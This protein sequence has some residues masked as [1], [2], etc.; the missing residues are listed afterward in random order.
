MTARAPLSFDP[1]DEAGRQWHARWGEA[2][3]PMMAVTSLMRVQQLVLG[4]LNELLAPLELTFARYELLML[5][6]LSGGGSLPLS[7]L[8]VRLQVHPT[9]VTSLLD[10]LEKHGHAAR[11]PHP[12]DRRTTLAAITPH[13]RQVAEEATA[14]LNGE[15]FGTAPLPADELR[16]LTA[17]LRELRLAAGDF[18][19]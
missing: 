4:R 18:S 12:T 11:T 9:S 14:L 10:R 13:G 2:A 19:A 15:R 6:H 7:K 17:T 5:L 16:A 8:G 3:T 1:I